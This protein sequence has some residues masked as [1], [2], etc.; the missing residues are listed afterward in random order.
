LVRKY[1]ARRTTRRRITRRRRPAR[2]PKKVNQLKRKRD[3]NKKERKAAIAKVNNVRAKGQKDKNAMNFFKRAQDAVKKNSG[4]KVN[5]APKA[6]PA[7]KKKKSSPWKQM[8]SEERKARRRARALRR[9][10]KLLA[11][12]RSASIAS[13]APSRSVSPTRRQSW[14]PRTLLRKR[15]LPEM[16]LLLLLPQLVLPLLLLLPR[17]PLQ[18]L[19]LP[20][21][22]PLLLPPPTRLWWTRHSTTP[23]RVLPRPRM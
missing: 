18:M 9:A 7:I 22:P 8:T 14:P 6:A 16:S 23:T 12:T 19:V 21:L 3:Q 4:T 20:L 17:P 10:P 2:K 1:R 11:K 5:R 13:P 15:L